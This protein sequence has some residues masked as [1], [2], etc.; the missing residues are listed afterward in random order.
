M[1]PAAS[2]P[3]HVGGVEDGMRTLLSRGASAAPGS[4]A[5]VGPPAEQAGLS[6]AIAPPGS[7]DDVNPAL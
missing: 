7:V 3:V 2:L 6:Y 5:V 1:G 4:I